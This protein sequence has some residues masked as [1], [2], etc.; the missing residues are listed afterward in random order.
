MARQH[1][2]PPGETEKLRSEMTRTEHE[3]EDAKLAYFNSVEYQGGE[4]T[5][6]RLKGYAEAFI[7]ANHDLQKSLYG[8]VRIRL[9]VSRLLRE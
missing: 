6:E 4:M 1:P 9:N 8:R 2:D 5:Y 3:L 7:S